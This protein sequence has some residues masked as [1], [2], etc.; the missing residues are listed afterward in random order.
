MQT[1]N[2][3]DGMGDVFK[4]P[5]WRVPANWLAAASLAISLI[6]VAI[7]F[8]SS[9]IAARSLELAERQFGGDRRIVLSAQILPA[10]DE[11]VLKP[12]DPTITVQT[13]DYMLPGQLDER[14]NRT[15]LSPPDFALPLGNLQ[16]AIV[17]QIRGLNL[18][19]RETRGENDEFIPIFITTSYLARGERFLDRS[20]YH[21]LYDWEA[22]GEHAPTVTFHA[23]IPDRPLKPDE[24]AKSVLKLQW[25]SP[26]NPK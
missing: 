25:V 24:D 21:L 15:P 6:A 2:A 23:L 11:I 10:R 4:T 9:K 5:W 8:V 17:R 16:Y 26:L 14:S 20:I 12:V 7:S 19:P 22:T 13:V 1:A 18:G 3:S